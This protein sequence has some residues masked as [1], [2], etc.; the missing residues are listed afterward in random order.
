M[1]ARLLL[2]ISLRVLGLWLVFKIVALA[3][4]VPLFMSNIWSSVGSDSTLYILFYIL[5]T[6]LQVVLGAALTYC[7]PRIAAVFYPPHAET[8]RLQ[9]NVGPGD[10]YR[11]ASFVLG[12]YLL[13]HAVQP[14]CRLVVAG[15]RGIPGGWQESQLVVDAVTMIVNTAA[16]TLL[17]FGSNWIG[18]FLSNLR[19]DPDTIPKQQISIAAMLVLILLFALCLGVIRWMTF[20]GV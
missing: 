4:V 18:K 15:F 1:S 16:G 19:Y 6:A 5:P 7:A 14:A 8:E 3:M 13:V 2:E 17:V 10:V 12:A 11:T 20:G 9:I